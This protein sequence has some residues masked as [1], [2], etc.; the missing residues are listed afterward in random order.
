MKTKTKIEKQLKRKNNPKLVRTL[1]ASKKLKNWENVA[2]LLSRPARI[3]S[4]INL[5]RI[6]EETKGGEVVVIPGKVLSVGNLQK[7]VRIAALSASKNALEKIK[8]ANAEFILL[9]EEIK[10]NPEAK[11]V[12]IIK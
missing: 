6:N 7:K 8:N 2:S 4:E 3:S 12:K 9:E 11:G 10:S 5:D 1:L